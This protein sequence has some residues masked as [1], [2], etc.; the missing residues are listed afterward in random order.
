MK[1]LLA[2]LLS[3]S[4]FLAFSPALALAKKGEEPT[5][6]KYYAPA[7]EDAVEDDVYDV[8]GRPE[9]KVKVHVYKQDAKRQK[10]GSG[11]NQPAL[12]CNLAD[13]DSSAVVPAAG[14]HLSTAAPVTY[15]LNVSSVP[16]T[17]GGSNLVT[18]ATNSYGQW[19]GAVLG[20][21]QV[22]R[23]TNT[24]VNRARY[25]GQNVIA[26]GRTSNTALAVTYIWYYTATGLVAET[27][28]IFN[29]SVPWAWSNPATWVT[30]TG[31]TCAY[32][33]VYDAQGILTH[34]L[35]HWMGLKDIYTS[36]FVDNTMY[37]YGS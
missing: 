25:D 17:V 5:K 7:S 30:A 27:D 13:T 15:R 29:S 3:F 10:P 31:T 26:W 34:E 9:L 23:G 24:T 18:I 33:N 6:V 35:G 32:K 14:W 12:Q 8:E 2:F 36:D 22:A 28:T 1:K 16:S 21:V 11:S 37:G 4:M 20:K 19:T